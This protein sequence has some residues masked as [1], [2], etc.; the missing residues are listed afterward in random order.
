MYCE[1]C[2]NVINNNTNF[3]PKCGNVIETNVG[4][5][6]HIFHDNIG[7]QSYDYDMERKVNGKNLDILM[8]VIL[9]FLICFLGVFAS[10]ILVVRNTMKPDNIEKIVDDL[11]ISKIKIGF[12]LENDIFDNT[13]DDNIL[14]SKKNLT[15]DEFICRYNFGPNKEYLEEDKIAEILDKKFIKK[16]ASDKINDYIKDIFYETGDGVVTAKELEKL[17]IKNSN[18]IC[19]TADY[20]ISEEDIRFLVKNLDDNGFLEGT[21]LS[22]YREDNPGTLSLIKNLF[23]YWLMTLLIAF[24]FLLTAS[25]FLLQDKKHRGICYVGANLIIIGI[26]DIILGILTNVMVTIINRDIQFGLYFWQAILKPIQ[27]S[28]ITI[29]I[30]AAVVGV[31]CLLLYIFIEFVNNRKSRV[32]KIQVNK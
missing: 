9:C 22:V 25:I 10:V 11:E 31:L 18:T 32:N 17:I 27:I 3:C 16:F 7:E 6:Q 19:E 14:D 4:N 21:D 8:T 30:I 20:S 29:G 1:K 28:A 26:V 12:L 15:L 5:M 13:T 24:S 2:G 23:S